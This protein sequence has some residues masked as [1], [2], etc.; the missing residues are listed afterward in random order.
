MIRCSVCLYP[1][2]KPDLAFEEGVCAACRNY[3]NRPTIDWDQ[4]KRELVNILSDS[5]P[6][7]S[8]YD[9][10]VPSSGGKDSHYQVLTLLELGARPLVVTATTDLV[11]NVGQSNIR[12]LA[13]Y[14]TTVE[15]SPNRSVRG[16][17]CRLGLELVGDISWPE[18]AS[19]FSV[20]WRVAKDFGIPLL[21]YG[22]NPQAEYGGP[23]GSEGAADMTRRWVT[24]FGGFLGLRPQDFVGHYGITANDML[25]YALPEDLDDV[26]AYFLGQFIPWDSHRNA[27]IAN[28]AGMNQKLPSLSNWWPFENLDNALTGLHDH[29]MYRKYGYGRFVGQASVDIRAE[30]IDRE[31][32]LDICRVHDGGF[33]FKYMGVDIEDQLEFLGMTMDELKDAL[34]IHTNWNLFNGEED[35][36]PLLKEFEYEEAVGC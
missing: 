11:T 20:P 3:A 18:H 21:F 34:K 35:M 33:P 28:E 5:K 6:N 4:R 10:I 26:E 36:R 17:L 8:G 24:E 7:G 14:A 25:D 2:T 22:E 29:G 31:T 15:M 9:C 19:I 13:R 12:N 16:R 32:A 23:V 30:R 1:D 27:R